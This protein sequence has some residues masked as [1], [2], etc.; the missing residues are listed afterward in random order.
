MPRYH[1]CRRASVA[2]GPGETAEVRRRSARAAAAAESAVRPACGCWIEAG[3]GTGW[4]GGS[5]ARDGVWRTAARQDTPAR[6]RDLDSGSRPPALPGE[7]WAPALPGD[8]GVAG[9]A[10]LGFDGSRRRTSTVPSGRART[11]WSAADGLHRS[12]RNGSPSGSLPR[13]SSSDLPGTRSARRRRAQRRRGSAWAP[14]RRGRGRGAGGASVRVGLNRLRAATT[15]RPPAARG[16]PRARLARCGAGGRRAAGASGAGSERPSR[17]ARCSTAGTRRGEA[18]LSRQRRDIQRLRLARR[19][20]RMKPESVS[21]A[22]RSLGWLTFMTRTFRSWT[23]SNL[24][25][26]SSAS[27]RSTS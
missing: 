24:G 19:G 15:C 9:G 12:A 27:S 4:P 25:A 16:S 22:R 17:R 23:V 13:A 11:T 21:V 7:G 8:P 5:G 26:F 14:G 18:T 1:F 6:G 20:G 10:G 2:D 3:G